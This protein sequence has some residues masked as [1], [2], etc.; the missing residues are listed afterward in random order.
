MN[1]SNIQFNHY[2]NF[3]GVTKSRMYHKALVKLSLFVLPRLRLLCVLLHFPAGTF[4][5]Y[6]GFRSAVLVVFRV[7]T[8]ISL[9]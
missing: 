1:L 8:N 4:G 6:S 9:L 5:R 2:I 7:K 3:L